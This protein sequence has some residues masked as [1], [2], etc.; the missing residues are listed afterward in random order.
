MLLEYWIAHGAGVDSQ[1]ADAAAI[2]KRLYS[3]KVRG[4][5]AS[6]MQKYLRESGFRVFPLNGIGMTFLN[7]SSR[8]GRSSPAY[9]RATPE[10]RYTTW[11]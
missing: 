2:Q 9:N 11:S 7:S 5:D 3:R 1:R 4:I 6:D 8:G 10:P